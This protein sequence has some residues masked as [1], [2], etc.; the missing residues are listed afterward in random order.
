M[1]WNLVQTQKKNELEIV[2]LYNYNNTK[3]ETKKE[4]SGTVG[5][6]SDC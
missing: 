6:V 4:H 1:F 2:K 3:S 5:K